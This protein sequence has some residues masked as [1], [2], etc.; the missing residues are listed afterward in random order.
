M[1][2]TP[3]VSPALHRLRGWVTFVG[4]VVAMCAI[5]KLMVFGFVHFTDVRYTTVEPGPRPKSQLAVVHSSDTP[6]RTRIENGRV[7]HETESSD[8]SVDP[9]RV[10]SRAD[11]NLRHASEFASAAGLVG[12]IML[13]FLAT[14]G[15]V[16]AAGGAV[17]GIE[18]TV[19]ACV[20]SAAM[21]LFCVPWQDIAGAIEIPGVFTSYSEVVS[22]SEHV[23]QQQAGGL[24]LMAGFVLLPALALGCA[25]GIVATFRAGVRAGVIVTAVSELDQAIDKELT[26]ITERGV[27]PRQPKAVGALFR[28]IGDDV[29]APAG[30]GMLR[31]RPEPRDRGRAM[32]EGDPG[33]PLP[34]PI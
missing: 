16:I 8:S 24:R 17:P 7:I 15:T 5:T 23:T 1:K 21:L 28:A 12:A 31:V 2:G 26:M 13:A 19:A 20:W 6:A 33:T 10:L 34:R 27:A 3:H 4:A 25:V 22:A 32:T 18:K 9:N 14:L 11:I 30:E 29:E